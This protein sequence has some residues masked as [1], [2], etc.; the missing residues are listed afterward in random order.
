VSANG[1]LVVR[2]RTLDRNP[3]HVQASA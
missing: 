3:E 1:T 2:Q